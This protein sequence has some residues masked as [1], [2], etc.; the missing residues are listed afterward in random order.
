MDKYNTSHSE[1]TYRLM[2][3][4]HLAIVVFCAGVALWHFKEV[5]LW[6]F[7]IAFIV[8]DAIGYLPGLIKYLR[9]KKTLIDPLYHYLYNVT[10]S[11]LTWGVVIAAWWYALGYQW[12]WAMLAIPIHISG[13]RGLFGNVFKPI[14][15]SFEPN[16]ATRKS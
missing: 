1:G 14:G 7:V 5:N 6:R 13:D 10:H 11:Y 2:R 4:E 3:A 12:E 8:I 16:P 9:R 15:R